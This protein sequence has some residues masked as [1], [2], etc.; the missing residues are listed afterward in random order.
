MN[1][2]GSICNMA[3][4]YKFL[5][6][7]TLLS[8]LISY[9][10]VTWF[11]EVLPA[12]VGLLVVIYLYSN[13][14]TFSPLLTTVIVVHVFILAIGGIFTYPRV[15]FFG[16][17]DFLGDTLDWSRNN[18]DK[19]GHFMQGFT[20][21]IATKEMLVK[22]NILRRGPVLIFL[23]ISVS[24]AVSALYELIEYASLLCLGDGAEDFIGAQGDPF[25]TQTDIFWAMIGSVVASCVAAPYKYKIV[26]S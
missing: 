22:S 5:L 17:D 15:P 11:M 26:K 7:L 10:Q 16:P 1:K 13:G 23:S 24:L 20:P 4:G 12:I 19:L 9:D 6:L 14:V 21:F 8:G 18:Y 25:D 2:L 3:F